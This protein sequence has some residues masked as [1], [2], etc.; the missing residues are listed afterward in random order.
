MLL[1]RMFA[2]ALL[3]L[4]PSGSVA[5]R[6]A[7][8]DRVA[9]WRSDIDT[10]LADIARQHYVYR[11]RPLPPA[12]THDADELRAAVLRLSDE[13]MLVEL[14]HLMAYLGD[15]HSYMLPFG[16][17]RGA[18]RVL[19]LRFYL[20]SDGLFVIDA[21]PGS[22]RWIGSRVEGVGRTPIDT[23]LA[24]LTAYVS[25]D[26]PMGT[27]W[28][29]PFLLQF[30]GTLEA[31]GDGIAPGRIQLTLRDR[32]G[33]AREVA[34]EPVVLPSPRGV[35]KLVPSRLPGAPAVPRYL[36]R[37]SDTYWFEVLPEADAVYV[38]FNQVMDSPDE[39]LAEFAR[40]L[41][42]LLAERH[43]DALV[44]DV[45]HN[46]GGHAELLPPLVDV[47]RAYD[48]TRP[49][50]GLYVLTSRNTFSAAQIFIAQV[51]RWTH[52][53]FA[54]EPSSSRPNFVG[55]ENAVVLPW[56]GARG[57]ISNRYHESIPGDTRE[58]IE[59]SINVELS[60]ADYFANRDPVMDAVLRD[61]GS[62]RR[63]P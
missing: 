11:S 35:P 32:Q 53:T 22:D 1:R 14:E 33:G 42:G 59:P 19:P 36:A 25:R 8:P 13:R 48:A 24:R 31:I 39:T 55:E 12:L 9:G 16:A 41:G 52:A 63:A 37:V 21:A 10:L 60:S 28:I 46:N 5:Q 61:I 23:V 50:G 47:L 18:A 56:S 54:G 29:G 34:L 27:K 62:R 58:W 49:R 17:R 57:S 26:N 43:P 7:D 4:A 38:Q 40:K 44:V 15:G 45:R 51:D 6:L 20:F 3:V 2:V 30:P